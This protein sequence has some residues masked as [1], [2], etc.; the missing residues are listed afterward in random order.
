MSLDRLGEIA[1]VSITSDD[2]ASDKV[3]PFLRLANRSDEE[4]DWS[5][6]TKLDMRLQLGS[7]DELTITIM[8]KDND[9]AWRPDMGIWQVGA[10]L[11]VF[12]GY[13]GDYDTMQSFTIVSH[14]VSYPEESSETMTVRAVSDLA[15]A[16]HN[17]DARVFDE[18]DDGAA[19]DAVCSD[20]GWINLVDPELLLSNRKR[21]KKKG[22]SDLDFL[23]GIALDAALGPPT[24]D[25]LGNLMMPEAVLGDKVYAR[26][27]AETSGAE[28]LHN[29][30]PSR[31]GGA[32]AIQLKITSWDPTQEKF[33]SVVYQIDEFS[34]DPT[35]VFEGEA[36]K[37]AIPKESTT[38]G[39][40]LQVISVRGHGETQK[41]D[42]IATGRFMDENDAE[43]LAR[44]WFELKEKLSR[45]AVI[46]VDGDPSLWPYVAVQVEG[47]M[48]EMDKGVW[49]PT[50]VEHTLDQGGWMARLTCI[51]VVSETTV[52]AVE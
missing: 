39:L 5:G 18:K 49:L 26:G 47:E 51:R 52:S 15:R 43:D 36:A 17:K 48:A 41:R 22:K 23:R 3:A 29:F 30:R 21:V 34:G 8:A 10:T 2:P 50:V 4:I 31:E 38:T 14:T 16:L 37:S 11:A 28:R 32:D 44:R 9:G 35:V 6:L 24:V 19:L 25:A 7:A 46:T 13:N 20:Y 40:T 45:W 42:V 12:L 33:I 27:Q 1:N